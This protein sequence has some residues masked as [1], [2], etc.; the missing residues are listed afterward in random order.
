MLKRLLASL[1]VLSA[2]ATM[3]AP[4]TVWSVAAGS[5][6]GHQ[7]IVRYLADLPAW[8]NRGELP[9]L[10]AISWPFRSSSGM[11]SRSE[12]AEMND[13]EDSVTSAVEKQRIGILTVVVT[14]NGVAEW[15]FYARSHEDF[16][17]ILNQALAGKPRFPVQISLQNDPQWSAYA[18][19]SKAK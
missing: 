8:V 3:A 9:N 7:L 13:F 14:G 12:K 16:M 1:A 4:S 19:F 6:N 10:V 5:D 2:P 15:Q 17:R 11:P 18:K